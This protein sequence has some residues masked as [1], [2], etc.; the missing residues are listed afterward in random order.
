MTKFEW[1]W[2][3][4]GFLCIIGVI[5]MATPLFGPM[6]ELTKFIVIMVGFVLFLVGMELDAIVQKFKTWR[7]RN[8]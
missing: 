3:P 8:E 4:Q 6:A 1:I 2:V 5:L 7:K